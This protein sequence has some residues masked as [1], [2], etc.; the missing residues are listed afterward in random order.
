M[1][2]EK[3][4]LVAETEDGENQT[5]L[6][7]DFDKQLLGLVQ[8][9]VGAKETDVVAFNASMLGIIGKIVSSH[10]DR[11]TGELINTINTTEYGI[12]H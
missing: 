8:G 2:N 9:D 10:L 12:V 6:V 3:H 1:S 11:E 7:I 5:V 4:F